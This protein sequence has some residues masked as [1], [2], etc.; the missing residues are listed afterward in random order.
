MRF[1][2][3]C[4]GLCVIGKEGSTYL[5]EGFIQSLWNDANSNFNE[6]S[7]LA[8]KNADGS[9]VGCWG[10]MSNISMEFMPWEDNFTKGL[11]LAGVKCVDNAIAPDGWKKWTIPAFQFVKI[12]C[13]DS[14]TFA[15]GLDY[16]AKNG[17][18]LVG[19][20]QDYTDVKS[21]QNYMCFPIK[22]L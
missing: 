21:G 14:N 4:T 12:P 15:Y 11:Y 1:V 13:S 6:V 22:R 9:L 8:K 16:L 5:G 19:A 18:E 3:F 7:E 2:M 17:Y 20:V 10:V